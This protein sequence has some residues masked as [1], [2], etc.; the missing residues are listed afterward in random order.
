MAV[1]QR[2]RTFHG[3]AGVGTHR[4]IPVEAAHSGEREAFHPFSW[5]TSI[6]MC[7]STSPITGGE[8]IE[9]CWYAVCDFYAAP[10]RRRLLALPP[11]VAVIDWQRRIDYANWNTR[12]FRLLSSALCGVSL[13]KAF[14]SER[15]KKRR[16]EDG[17]IVQSGQGV[18]GNEFIPEPALT[19]VGR[20]AF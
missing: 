1:R 9:P 16:T 10:F 8:A 12:C 4:N 14:S 5:L 18:T 13:R 2:N 17:Q 11:S 19:Q 6:F 15:K 20:S 7:P 3:I